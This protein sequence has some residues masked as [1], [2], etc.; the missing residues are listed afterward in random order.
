[1]HGLIMN[2]FR[3]FVASTLGG[4]A[5][6]ELTEAAG[7]PSDSYFLGEVYP[8]AHLFKLVLAASR[9][10]GTPLPVL[11]EQFGS[12]ITPTLLRVYRPL[13]RSDWRT[14]EIV[15]HTE[16]VIHTAIRSRDPLATPP[17]LSCERVAPD[18]VRIDYRSARRLCSLAKGIVRGLAQEL[19]D[20]VAITERECMHLGDARCLIQV[21]LLS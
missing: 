17:H 15:E 6:E 5:W 21:Q 18:A 2:Q 10:T 13:L 20:R 3:Q 11:L 1:M 12:F 4:T 16:Q 14:L 7:V 19:G 9:R 8:D